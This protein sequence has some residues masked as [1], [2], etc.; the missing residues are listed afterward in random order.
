VIALRRVEAQSIE[1]WVK[2]AGGYAS[3]YPPYTALEGFV[4][5]IKAQSAESTVS[6]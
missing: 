6:F 5:W 1:G 3:L 2:Q 4:G